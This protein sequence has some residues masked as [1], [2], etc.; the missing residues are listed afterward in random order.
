[1]DLQDATLVSLLGEFDTVRLCRSSWTS[2]T[3][4]VNISVLK[5]Q[6]VEDH[7]WLRYCFILSPRLILSHTHTHTHTDL[8]W[9]QTFI[10]VN[11]IFCLPSFLPFIQCVKKVLNLRCRYG[12][13][14]NNFDVWETRLN[15]LYHP[16]LFSI[17]PWVGDYCAEEFVWHLFSSLELSCD[18]YFLSDIWDHWHPLDMAP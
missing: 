6:L 17:C 11:S 16:D 18:C 13:E 9:N 1:M 15:P 8:I 7:G 2:Y 10:F 14:H 12:F 4:A 3:S 5:L